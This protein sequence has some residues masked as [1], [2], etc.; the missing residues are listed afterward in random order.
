MSFLRMLVIMAIYMFA[1]VIFTFFFMIIII[2]KI[3]NEG[4]PLSQVDIIN[5]FLEYTPQIIILSGVL[6]LFIFWLFY[7]IK[8]RKLVEVVRM[9]KISFLQGF[10]A[11]IFGCSLLFLNSYIAEFVSFLF[12]SSFAS[13]EISTEAMF[14]AG[15]IVLFFAVAIMAPIIE[16]IMFRG[17]IFNQFLGKMKMKWIIVLQGLMFGA[18][19]MNI[20]QGS[21]A[22]LMGMIMGL[23]LLY[24][25]SLWIPILIHFG[26][27]ALSTI[28][29]YS[30]Y[31]SFATNNNVLNISISLLMIFI[32]APLCFL[33]FYKTRNISY[34]HST[35]EEPKKNIKIVDF[36]LNDIKEQIT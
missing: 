31:E 34:M 21:Y 4:I 30:G 8:N 3:I 5:M 16:E 12:P 17:L 27:N 11:V 33:Y 14:S 9:K 15:P 32:V 13:Y 36:P 2:I 26:N 1:Q 20:I 7:K 24:S 22:S 23:T 28:L 18:F 35:G 29:Y 25:R 10:I 6:T 19:H